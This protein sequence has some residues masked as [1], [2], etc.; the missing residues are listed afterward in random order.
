M[1]KP[2][3]VFPAKVPTFAFSTTVGAVT[4]Q[5]KLF[6]PCNDARI[7]KEK[8]AAKYRAE[9]LTPIP[10][11]PERIERPRYTPDS[12]HWSDAVDGEQ[13]KPRRFRTRGDA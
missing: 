1:A 5:T 11:R 8:A 3:E 12:G 9:Q 4:V 2:L 10:P 13:Q 7:A 6:G